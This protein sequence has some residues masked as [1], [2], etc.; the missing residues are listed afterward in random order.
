MVDFLKF[1]LVWLCLATVEIRSFRVGILR[2]VL[3]YSRFVSTSGRFLG[4]V[5]VQLGYLRVGIRSDLVEIPSVR[6]G[7][8]SGLVGIRSV[9]VGIRSARF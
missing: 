8:R 1:R 4:S 3:G 7:I 9:C 6:V 5:R 2:I